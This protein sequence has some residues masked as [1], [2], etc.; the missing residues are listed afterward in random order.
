MSEPIILSTPVTHSDWISHS[1]DRIG[2]GKESVQY[3]LE[4][5]KN[6]GMQKIY[7][8]CFDG[9]LAGYASQLADGLSTGFDDDNYT[10]WDMANNALVRWEAGVSYMK[11]YSKDFDILKE[12]VAYGHE[13]G[14]EIHAW[15]TI[16]EDDHG[17]GVIS[18]FSRKHPQFRWVKQ[19]GMP[20]NSQLSFAY[21]QVREYKLGLIKEILEYEIDGI[22]FDWIRTGDVRNEPQA[23]PD[24]TADFGYEKPLTDAFQEQTGRNPKDIPNNGEAWVRFRA[25]PQTL[26]MQQ[27]HKLIKARNKNIAISMMG[28][29]PWSYRCSTARVNGNLHGLLIDVDT[30]AKRGLI[31][32]VVAW[33]GYGGR[34]LSEKTYHHAVAE[35]AGHCDVWM[36]WYMP[37]AIADFRK[38]IEAAESLGSRQILYWE[39]DYLDLKDRAHHAVE[40]ANTMLSYA[41]G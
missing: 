25:Q 8:R 6:A 29:T 35:V 36:Y 28:H 18:R 26:F 20:Y 37:E 15:V 31:D 10:T 32:E 33:R 12:A 16:N 21:E 24:G 5:C 11:D 23:T 40:L 19:A 38:S 13:I 41:R 17:W 30:W 7:W 4:R 34:D 2:Q 22:F 39:A 14:L 9:G 1:R 27:A 3:V